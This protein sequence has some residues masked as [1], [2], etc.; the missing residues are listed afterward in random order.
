MSC[1]F[2]TRGSHRFE[3]VQ[4]ICGPLALV[5]TVATCGFG[6]ESARPPKP[7]VPEPIA[8]DELPLPRSSGIPILLRPG[9]PA[10]EKLPAPMASSS[11]LMSRRTY[12]RLPGR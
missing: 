1:S 9:K 11:P 12:S 2:G 5:A 8:V 4:R 6:A 3:A 7:P 10:P